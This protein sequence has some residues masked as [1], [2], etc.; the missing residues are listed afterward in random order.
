MRAAAMMIGE[1][2]ETCGCYIATFDK[3]ILR[4]GSCTRALPNLGD[5]W[6][7]VRVHFQTP[8]DYRLRSQW[9]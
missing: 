1:N 5:C 6:S 8:G 7:W 3:F 4:L 9:G 2:R